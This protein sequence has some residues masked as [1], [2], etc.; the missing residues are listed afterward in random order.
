MELSFV[1]LFA[2][3]KNQISKNAEL[4]IIARATGTLNSLLII[5]IIV[6]DR[7]TIAKLSIH[8]LM[9]SIKIK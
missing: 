1:Y 5:I 2:P 9:E 8:L 3:K 6:V 4:L 7:R